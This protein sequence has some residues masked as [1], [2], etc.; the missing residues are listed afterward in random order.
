MEIR[1][2][3]PV[4]SSDGTHVGDVDRLVID[5]ANRD[6]ASLIIQEGLILTEDRIIETDAIERVADDGTIHLNITADQA[7]ELP[8]FD[9]SMF[10]Y[11]PDEDVEDVLGYQPILTPKARTGRMLVTTESMGQRGQQLT[12]TPA[13]GADHTVE[14]DV[15]SS[16]PH[17]L[18][19]I[20]QGT[21]VVD[22]RGE[23][24]GTVDEVVYDDQGEVSGF[25]IKRGVIFTHDVHVPK[26][27]IGSITDEHVELTVTTDEAEQQ[28][29]ASR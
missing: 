21:D 5:P 24:V 25:A 13:A 22:N 2:D 27:W 4:V 8:S 9:E 11:F 17:D 20:D 26:E 6:I 14:Q 1:L 12:R 7:E 23:K 28:G 3:A 18:V 10:N 19:S 15:E 16:L 29:R